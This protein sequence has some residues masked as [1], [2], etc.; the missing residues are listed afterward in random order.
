VKATDASASHCVGTQ[1]YSVTIGSSSPAGDTVAIAGLGSLAGANGAHFKTQVQ[2]TNPTL[3]TIAGKIVYHV[4]GTSG[5]ADDPSL[6]YTLAAWQT[7][8]IDDV[9]AAMGLSG[10]GTADIVPTSGPAPA[11]VV[12]IFNDDGANGTAGFTEPTFRAPD[13][14]Q[15][16]DEAVLILPAD[17]VNFRFNLGVRTL[18]SGIAA[19]FTIWDEAGNL[20]A[21]VQKSY[22]ANFFAQGKGTD[23]LGVA[24]LPTNGSIGVTVTQGSGF[25]FGSTVDNRGSQ[26]TSTQFTR[27]E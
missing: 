18:G 4:G 13:A 15:P 23:F 27:H 19:T 11:A 5:S 20:V 8:N 7:V 6:P 21:T 12:K 17:P 10:L 16:G 3:S 1:A 14:L 25:F 22:A 26:D 24:S 9:L 2:L